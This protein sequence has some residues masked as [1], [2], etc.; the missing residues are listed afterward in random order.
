MD[1][2]LDRTKEI[3]I[4]KCPLHLIA[5]TMGVQLMNFMLYSILYQST[6][7]QTQKLRRNTRGAKLNTGQ[8]L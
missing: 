4:G 5:K 2:R 3:K 7:G 8:Q 1:H 6:I